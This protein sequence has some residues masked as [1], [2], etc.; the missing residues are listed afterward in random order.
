[1]R[2]GYA[3]IWCCDDCTYEY[4]EIP[5]GSLNQE[6]IGELEAIMENN[7]YDEVYLP[8]FIKK[9]PCNTCSEEEFHSCDYPLAHVNC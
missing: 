9:Y 3:D 8:E 6:Q 5:D 2:I 7:W 1:M 4:Y